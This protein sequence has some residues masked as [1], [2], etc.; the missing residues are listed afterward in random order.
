MSIR[1]TLLAG[2]LCLI[3]TALHAQHARVRSTA[4][5][6]TTLAQYST[7]GNPTSALS[8][9]DGKYLFVSV[10]N[11]DAPN[12]TG[13]DSAAGTRQN[14]NSGIQVFRYE[15]GKLSPLHFVRIGGTGANGLVLLPGAKTLAVGVGDAGVAF[16]DVDGLIRGDAT[17]L[18][19]ISGAPAGTFDIVASKDGRYIF[20]ANEYG[21]IDGQRGNVGVTSTGIDRNGHVHQPAAIGHVPLGDV[22]PSLSISPDGSR[23]YVA[24]EL[25]PPSQSVTIAGKNNPLLTKSD[26]VQKKGT[27]P[28]SG[29][30]IS[31]VDTR[32]AV[33]PHPED[34]VLSRIA[35][36]CSPV[37]IANSS[38]SSALFVS[39]RGDNIVLEF[40]A[41]KLTTDPEHAFRRAI[42]TG[43]TA[44]VSDI[45]GQD[46]FAETMS[47]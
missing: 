5:E 18:L 10:T 16:L 21:V 28:K 45:Q 3:A 47:L 43:G 22:V 29:G 34:A 8:T 6:A 42:P 30:F 23:L 13:P 14:V 15:H 19:A 37:R 17:L 38:D 2:I 4:E 7:A 32:R 41:A 44:P 12:F 35:A 27:P 40:D 33:G 46:Y 39:G 20:S 31:V 11:V 25:V 9:P 1:A 26:C 36:G 24:T